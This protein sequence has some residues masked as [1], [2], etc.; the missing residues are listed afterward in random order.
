MKPK[1]SSTMRETQCFVGTANKKTAIVVF[2]HDPGGYFLVKINNEFGGNR[3]H[4]V[5][6]SFGLKDAMDMANEFL[7]VQT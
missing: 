4:N 7:G 1:Q 2:A 6:F 5:A 3:T